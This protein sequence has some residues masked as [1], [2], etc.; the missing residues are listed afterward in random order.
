MVY[1]KIRNVSVE[2][3]IGE[4]DSRVMARVSSEVKYLSV[5][6]RDDI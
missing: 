5:A 6:E 1:C 2:D 4:S 3:L